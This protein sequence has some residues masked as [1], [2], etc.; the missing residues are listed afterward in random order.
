MIV[1]LTFLILICIIGYLSQSF[2][3]CLVRGVNEAK[4]GKPLF[5]NPFC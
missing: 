1:E 5:L 2:G 3:L 4:A